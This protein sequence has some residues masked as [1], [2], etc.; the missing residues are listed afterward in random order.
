MAQSGPNLK[1]LMRSLDLVHAARDSLDITR[2]RSGKSYAFFRANG[3]RIRDQATIDRLNALAVPPAYTDV[4]YA[5]DAKAHLQAIGTDAAGR[6]QYRYHPAWEKVRETRKAARL[7]EMVAALPKLRRTVGRDLT[8]DVP[9]KTF[10]LAACVE[11]VMQTA[12]RAGSERYEATSG[13]RGATTLCKSNVKCTEDGLFLSFRGKGGKQISRMATAAKL[14]R[15]LDVL[16]K[17]PGRRL[18]QYRDAE[19]GL[20][21]LRAGDVNVYL[22]TISGCQI[23]LKDFRTLLASSLVADTLGSVEPA[24]SKAGR[25]RQ[26]KEAVVTAAEELGNTPT[27]CRKSYVHDSVIDAFESGKLKRLKAAKPQTSA[28]AAKLELLAAVVTKAA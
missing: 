17:L 10:A 24:T 11:L 21:A 3:A 22:K 1:R 7:A 25:R 2:R 6:L 8:G 5:R 18:F 4:R 15:S 16:R 23:S 9:T 27:V 12:I 19:G 26:I 20:H 28:N 14:C 13:N